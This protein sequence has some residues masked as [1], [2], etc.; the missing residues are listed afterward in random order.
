MNGF[1]FTGITG[2]NGKTTTAYLIDAILRGRGQRVTGLIGTIEY[3]LAGEMPHGGQ[4]HAR[5]AGRDPAWRRSWSSA[6]D[7][8]DHGS[9]LA[10]AGAW[11]GCTG[12]NSTP[13]CSRISRATIWIFISTMEEYA[14]AK[15]LLFVPGTARRRDGRC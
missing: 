15:R 5:I 3:R 2:T 1:C 13:R 7:A 4:Y 12:S 11:R 14:A 10:C 6:A 8:P 9:F